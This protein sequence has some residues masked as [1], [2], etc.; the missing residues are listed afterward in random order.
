MPEPAPDRTEHRRH[1]RV[2]GPFDGRLTGILTTE[3]KVYDLSVGG[4]L[5]EFQPPLSPGR[6]FEMEIELPVEG[7]V[8]MTA[9]SLRVFDGF[10][11]AARFV[12]MDDDMH[13]RL[14]L[15]IASLSEP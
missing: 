14:S 3:L 13:L 12:E 5:I 1:P 10:G 9:E 2:V 15:T 7:W 8:S 11:F 4:C 6:R